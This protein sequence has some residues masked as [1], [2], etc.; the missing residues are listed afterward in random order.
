MFA[1]I[2]SI[3][4]AVSIPVS[5]DLEAGFGD[6][7]DDVQRAPSP[8]AIAV[9][10]P[11]AAWKTWPTTPARPNLCCARDKTPSSAC[12]PP[13]PPST[14]TLPLCAD[15]P[16][17]M[18]FNRPPSPL[19]EADRPAMRLSRRWR[20]LPVAPAWPASRHRH[21]G[22]RS[23][24]PAQRM[25]ASRATRPWRNCAT[26]RAPHQHRQRPRPRRLHCPPPRR[27][28]YAE[29]GKLCLCA[30]GAVGEVL[31]GGGGSCIN[32]YLK[33]KYI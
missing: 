24:Q 8:R 1:A 7:L 22:A 30:D 12:A 28:R 16:H 21:P 18:L 17:R 20:R 29:Q 14:N 15:R 32:I 6:S 13:A 11:A 5:A 9:A 2:A 3:V 33:I 4:A 31:M 23:Q 25:T 26:W 27:R 19:A 10:A